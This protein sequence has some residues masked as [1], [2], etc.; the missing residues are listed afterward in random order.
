MSR[1]ADQLW[2]LQLERDDEVGND[3]DFGEGEGDADE[4]Q[5]KVFDV[6]VAIEKD[7]GRVK[8]AR[9]WFR[10]CSIPNVPKYSG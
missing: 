1:P 3:D 4:G 6:A 9:V 5:I 7:K 8:S 10:E 2:F